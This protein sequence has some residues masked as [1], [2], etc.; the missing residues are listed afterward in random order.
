[1]GPPLTELPWLARACPKEPPCCGLFWPKPCGLAWMEL[2]AVL[3][4]IPELPGRP[5][6]SEGFPFLGVLRSL[7]AVGL[8]PAEVGL[9]VAGLAET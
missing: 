7:V 9:G 3:G 8:W 4:F 5:G 6:V 2:R 1:M